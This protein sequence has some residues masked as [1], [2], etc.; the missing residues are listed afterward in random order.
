M[1]SVIRIC[2]SRGAMR[3]AGAGECEA[4]LTAIEVSTQ[5]SRSVQAAEHPGSALHDQAT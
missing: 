4:F 1:H 5:A 3:R 2:H